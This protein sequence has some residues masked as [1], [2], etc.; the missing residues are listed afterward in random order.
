V[1]ADRV[2]AGCGELPDG[3]AGSAADVHDHRAGGER[4]QLVAPAAP[5]DELGALLE[6]VEEASE[7][8][9]LAGLV[10]AVE[11]FQTREVERVSHRPT[12]QRYD[13]PSERRNHPRQTGDPWLREVANAF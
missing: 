12:L 3:G 11:A 13:E 8:L 7:L 10:D 5:G 9:G 4:Q 1:D 2:R 6:V